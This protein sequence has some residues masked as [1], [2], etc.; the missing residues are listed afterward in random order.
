M[1]QVAAGAYKHYDFVDDDGMR[2]LFRTAL[3]YFQ[4]AQRLLRRGPAR[5]PDHADERAE[6]PLTSST[7]GVSRSTGVP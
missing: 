1:V 7:A 3:Q 6:R 5:R 2:S 4:G